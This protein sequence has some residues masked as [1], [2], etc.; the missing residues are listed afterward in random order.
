MSAWEDAG[1]EVIVNPQAS[2]GQASSVR[3]GARLAAEAGC[4]A[5]LVALAD[6]P[7]VRAAHFGALVD[8][9]GRPGEVLVSVC[10]DVRMPPAIFGSE[11]FTALS[12]LEGD[13]GARDLLA[14][15][16]I[17]ECPPEWLIDIDTPEDLRNHGQ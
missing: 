13:R 11:H 6:M 2:L 10:E 4:D 8:L 17:V 14:S 15:G 3:L 12:G 1:L 16:Q 7:F 5:L 9:S